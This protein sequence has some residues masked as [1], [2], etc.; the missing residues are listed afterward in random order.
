MTSTVK[1]VWVSDDVDVP[2]AERE[3]T[4]DA[5]GLKEAIGGGW[6]E[7]IG[8]RG[9]TGYIDEEGKNKGMALNVRANHLAWTLGWPVTDFLVGPVVFLGPVDDEGEETDVT[10]LVVREAVLMGY[11]D[12]RV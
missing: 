7:G 10:D 11:L 5:D 1:T 8:A 2:V 6:L 3:F 9:W 12:E 4:A